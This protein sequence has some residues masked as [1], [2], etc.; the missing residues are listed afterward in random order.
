[1]VDAACMFDELHCNLRANR[2]ANLRADLPDVQRRVRVHASATQ[3][4]KIVEYLDTCRLKP[5]CFFKSIM[6]QS[7][8]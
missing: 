7:C 2:R 4:W 1:M 5:V 8:I 3:S 6:Q